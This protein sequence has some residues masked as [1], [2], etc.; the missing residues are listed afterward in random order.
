M[1]FSEPWT[2]AGEYVL[3]TLP[4]AERSALE[5]ELTRDIDLQAEVD[6]WQSRFAPLGDLVPAEEPSSHLWEAIERR[7]EAQG[8]RTP[9]EVRIVERLTRSV[10]IWRTTSV[11]AGGLAAVLAVVVAIGAIRLRPSANYLAVV[12]RSGTAPAMIVHVDLARASVQVRSVNAQAPDGRSLELWYVGKGRKPVS[13]GLTSAL[14]EPRRLPSLKSQADFEDGQIAVS[15]EPKGG[16]PTGSP[17][18]PIVYS[19]RLIRT[20]L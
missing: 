11:V 1:S 13:L 9:A 17:T 15:S 2:R 6:G 3:G 4:H 7:I 20:S 19:G 5:E 12:D 16:S 8:G 10:R 18:G 14:T